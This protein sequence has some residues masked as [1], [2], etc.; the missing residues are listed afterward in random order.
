MA[1]QAAWAPPAFATNWR[2]FFL[3]GYTVFL[4]PQGRLL[5]FGGFVTAEVLDLSYDPGRP[6]LCN[7]Q[8]KVVEKLSNSLCLRGILVLLYCLWILLME[9]V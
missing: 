2:P 6:N 7:G 9:N 4:H 8:P 1:G 5:A 3:F